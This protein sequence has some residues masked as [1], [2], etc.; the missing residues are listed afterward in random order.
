MLNTFRFSLQILGL[1]RKLS[2]WQ[3]DL[4]L[5]RKIPRDLWWWWRWSRDDDY[6]VMTMMMITWWWLSRDDNDYHVMMMITWWWYVWWWRWW[7]RDDD[8]DHVMTMI[9]WRWWSRDDDDHVVI[10][11]LP[12]CFACSEYFAKIHIYRVCKDR[13][14]LALQLLSRTP[15]FC[16]HCWTRCSKGAF[17]FPRNIKYIT[18]YRNSHVTKMNQSPKRRQ[19]TFTHTPFSA[20]SWQPPSSR[21]RNPSVHFSPVVQD[22]NRYSIEFSY[23]STQSGSSFFARNA[24]TFSSKATRSIRLWTRVMRW[25]LIPLMS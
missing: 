4:K 11:F 5:Q 15:V 22:V 8:D 24:K 17:H 1:Q 9:T 21:R 3:V 13:D 6:H 23:I 16:N 25:I 2:R 10:T 7:S 19:F 20:T 14:L 18:K 12:M